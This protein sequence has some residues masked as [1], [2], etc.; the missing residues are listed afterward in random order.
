MCKLTNIRP[1]DHNV[2]NHLFTHVIPYC[3]LMV[4][5]KPHLNRDLCGAQNMM[6]LPHQIC[7]TG[8]VTRGKT[9][10]S[11]LMVI[12]RIVTNISS[13][14]PQLK[15]VSWT[16]TSYIAKKAIERNNHILDILSTEY[17]Q[18]TS[19]DSSWSFIV[20]VERLW[21]ILQGIRRQVFFWLSMV[22]IYIKIPMDVG[23]SLLIWD[24]FL[25]AQFFH[26]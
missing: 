21:A 3:T 4:E 20:W 24:I 7:N 1:S 2:S 18:Q 11:N 9:D 10:T 17:A 15:W 23:A 8:N 14:L 16:Y 26:Q 12:I 25:P 19:T 5:T 6:V 13:R 22:V